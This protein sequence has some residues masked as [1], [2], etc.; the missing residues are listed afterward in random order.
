[1]NH[2]M[3]MA[4]KGGV[5]QM[6]G[7]LFEPNWI[8]DERNRLRAAIRSYFGI[9]FRGR[10][11]AR[12]LYLL[13]SLA[14]GTAYFVFLVTGIAVGGGLAIT[15]IGLPLLAV[16]MYA[17]CVLADADRWIMNLLVGTHIRRL[18]FP[19][20]ATGGSLVRRIGVR[21]RSSLTWRALV[22]LFLM[23]PLGIASFVLAVVLISVP[24][25][26]VASSASYRWIELDINGEKVHFAWVALASGAAFF[27]FFVCLHVLNLLAIAEGKLATLLLQSNPAPR[28]VNPVAAHEG[29]LL[30]VRP[31]RAGMALQVGAERVTTAFHSGTE[32]TTAALQGLTT[33]A[34]AAAAAWSG[35]DA[36]ATPA[37]LD[38][39]RA[40]PAV[41]PEGPAVTE[42]GAIQVEAAPEHSPGTGAAPA[43]TGPWTPAATVPT[44]SVDVVMRVVKVAGREVELTPKEFDLIALFAQNP[45]RPFSRDE[46]LDKIWR[47]DY[48]VTDRTIDTHVQRLRKKLGEQAEA[49][50]TV[51]GV[52]Y[53]FQAG[54]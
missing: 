10:T 41:P 29:P 31:D 7:E 21:A 2:S 28:Q 19:Q 48:E 53:K 44:I 8:E 39:A 1:M 52:G 23:F 40:M 5:Q 27:L 26:T 11:Y 17:W 36:A 4:G 51:W 46:L 34:K 43:T 54:E 14:T 22:W 12:I 45:G 13:A 20:S 33:R 42:E 6:T 32:K 9:A 16:T 25:A 49:I 47:N 37:A 50:Q 15:F 3:P 30:E 18:S 35:P 24:L 38:E